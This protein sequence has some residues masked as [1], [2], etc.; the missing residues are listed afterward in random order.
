MLASVGERS[1]V[2]K[3][4]DTDLDDAAWAIVEP[5]LPAAVPGGRLRTTNLR[6][7]VNAIFYLLRADC[8]GDFCRASIR[9][10]VLSI[11]ISAL[12]ELRVYG[13]GCN[14]YCIAESVWLRVGASAQP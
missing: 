2:S 6:I 1:N 9:H 11:I 13:R 10:A 8:L 14:G 12:G 5:E 3:L 7:V 4:Y